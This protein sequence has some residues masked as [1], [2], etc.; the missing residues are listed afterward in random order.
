MK[1]PHYTGSSKA[2]RSNRIVSEHG[3]TRSVVRARPSRNSETCPRA[4]RRSSSEGKGRN[5]DPTP[6]PVRSPSPGSRNLSLPGAEDEQ[7]SRSDSC[8]RPRWRP[9]RTKPKRKRR[10]PPRRCRAMARRTGAAGFL[11]PLV[12]LAGAPPSSPSIRERREMP[13]RLFRTAARVSLP[14]RLGCSCGRRASILAA[15]GV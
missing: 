3:V 11:L 14:I 10:E 9:G 15:H 12:L 4:E 13:T 8:E 1:G 7:R 2:G 5:P 6:F